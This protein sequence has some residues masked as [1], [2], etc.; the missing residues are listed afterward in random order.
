MA[1][2]FACK[3]LE[4]PDSSWGSVVSVSEGSEE[5]SGFVSSAASVGDVVSS[6]ESDGAVVST[7]AV[8]IVGVVPSSVAA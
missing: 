6:A 7:S 4:R 1:G 8:S 2:T 3:P 5:S